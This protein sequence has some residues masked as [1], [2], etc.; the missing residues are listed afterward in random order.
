MYSLLPCIGENVA[1]GTLPRQ[2]RLL[3]LSCPEQLGIGSLASW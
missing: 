3:T 1:A 2:Y